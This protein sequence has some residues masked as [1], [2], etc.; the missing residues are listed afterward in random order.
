MPIPY[1]AKFGML[2]FDEPYQILNGLDYRNTPLAPL[3]NLLGGIWGN[4]V[5]YE[6]IHYRYLAYCLYKLSIL[7]AVGYMY[8]KTKDYLTTL[9]MTIILSLISTLFPVTQNLYGWDCW[10]LPFLVCMI[11]LTMEYI[12]Q[13]RTWQLIVMGVLSAIIGF[14]R[15]PNFAII[16]FVCIVLTYT[17]FKELSRKEQIKAVG[18][19]LGISIIASFTLLC[20]MYGAPQS[21]LAYLHENSID[22]HGLINIIKPL[23]TRT[24]MY[25]TYPA[26]LWCSFE[27]LK[28]SYENRK[29]FLLASA[30][31]VAALYYFL[32]CDHSIQ[33][34]TVQNY[35]IGFVMIG[36]LALLYYDKSRYTK[37]IL[38]SLLLLGS[39]PFVGSNGGIIKFAALPIIPVLYIYMRP[40]VTR[41]I[42]IYSI[43]CAVALVLYAPFGLKKN[44]FADIGIDE[45][46]YEFSEGLLVNLRTSNKRAE[47]LNTFIADVAPYRN[48]RKLILRP[49]AEYIY[50]YVFLSRN[51]YLRH[52]FNGVSNDDSSYVDWVEQELMRQDDAVAVLLF[53]D[54]NPSLMSERLGKYCRKVKHTEKYSIYIKDNPKHANTCN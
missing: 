21:Y 54:N 15:I 24:F 45:S 46:N 20:L 49:G 12:A 44:G 3:S 28:K 41:Y 19:Y 11:I 25:L 35:T 32:R 4:M 8:F 31:V 10:S 47:K 6:W 5:G 29:C 9:I 50:E 42:Y 27:I 36:M 7:I 34:C 40:Y 1:L 16:P 37:S 43:L 52:R 23:V 53:D 18:T 48:Y 33:F 51:N 39:V 38:I 26:M 30:F 17:N 13:K 14:C 22:D 2:P